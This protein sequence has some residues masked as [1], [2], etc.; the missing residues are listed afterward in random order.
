MWN[1]HLHKRRSNRYNIYIDPNVFGKGLHIVHPGYIWIDSSS[2]VGNNCTVL[3][4][5]LFGKKKPGIKPPCIYI[6]DN[7][8]VG[9]GTTILGPI[10]IGNNVTIAANSIVIHDVPDNCI[11]GGNP[12]R[13]LKYKN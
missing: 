13:I 6:G 2:V 5:V 12:A 9:T 7:C 4:R 10:T 1:K 8:Y 3:P 11:V